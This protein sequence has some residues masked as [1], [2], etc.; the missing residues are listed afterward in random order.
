MRDSF[1]RRLFSDPF[2][3]VSA[4]I[5]LLFALA[6][7][8]A[9]QIV[10]YE[11]TEMDFMALNS[12]P[13][14]EHWLGT[15]DLGRDFL[16]RIILGTRLMWQSIGIVIAVATII[17]IPIGL[18]TGF[19][20]GYLDRIAMWFVDVIFSLPGLLIA[21]AIVA[22]L[23]TGLGNAMFAVGLVF[24]TR[25]IRLTRGLVLAEKEE[26]YVDSARVGGLTTGRILFRHMLPNIAPSLIV[27][28]VILAGVAILIEAALSFVGMG[29]NV[30]EPAW[31]LTLFNAVGNIQQ[32]PFGVVPPGL[33]IVLTA[34]SFNLIGDGIRDALGRDSRNH[35]LKASVRRSGEL[36]SHTPHSTESVLS[37]RGLEV[38]FPLA[39][40]GVTILNGVSLEIKAGETLGLVG[41]S[42]SGKSMTALSALGLVPS[43]G[44]VTSG[45]VEFEGR[46][47]T[48][49]SERE[50]NKIRGKEIAIIFQEPWAAL[51]PTMKVGKLLVEKIRTHLP[52]SKSKAWDKAVELL[53]LVQV[54]DAERR[55]TEYPHQF[56]G[57]MAQRVGIAMALACD[58]K[59]LICDE[60]TTA[61]DVTVQGQVLDLLKGIQERLGTAILF[62][63]HDLGVIAELCDRVAVMYSG[64]IVESGNVQGVF[65]RPQ[66]P[67][68]KALLETL[69]HHGR[70][71]GKLPVIDG[72]V[73]PPSAW[74]SGCRFHPRC[75]YAMEQCSAVGKPPLKQVQG[76]AHYSACIRL[77]EIEG[78][79]EL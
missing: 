34:L 2:T 17:G 6:A 9:E 47:M 19:V 70:S 8:F 27:Q 21:F 55:M 44:Q 74:P 48:T 79:S 10:P 57:G 31:G 49:L 14:A 39:H 15:D 29:V 54:P 4:I 24:S 45:S 50:L 35:G 53:K 16:T 78:L 68:T 71:E 42:G 7:I 51:D 73:P 25:I 12:G 65:E 30:G 76:Q 3:V 38:Q 23:G 20:G 61:L 28:G 56:S 72:L 40:E 67:Y 66:H 52:L 18:L 69:P 36:A 37:V 43:P 32:N 64:E 63:T 77:E 22:V 1:F 59:L 26:L 11:L 46:E 58:P 33:A 41:E 13:T 62:I 5:L 60:P 75:V